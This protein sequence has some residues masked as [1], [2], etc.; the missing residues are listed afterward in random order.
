[1][2][3]MLFCQRDIIAQVDV[4]DGRDELVSSKR[5]CLEC[6][7][8]IKRDFWNWTGNNLPVPGRGETSVCKRGRWA[9]ASWN[10]VYIA[11]VHRGLYG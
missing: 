4:S 5:V 3:D 6:L 10:I 1:M 2:C 8:Q 11:P 7:E 9:M